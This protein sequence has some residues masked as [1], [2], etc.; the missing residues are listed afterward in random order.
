[1]TVWAMQTLAVCGMLTLQYFKCMT[2]V[3]PVGLI[4]KG[5]TQRQMIQWEQPR[6]ISHC[7]RQYGTPYRTDYSG[8]YACTTEESGN[9]G[10][11]VFWKYLE[12]CHLII[13][14]IKRSETDFISKYPVQRW[15]MFSLAQH[16][17]WRQG[18]TAGHAQS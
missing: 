13:N 18:E 2:V 16:K 3:G 5:C 15:D 14:Q 17:E 4:V 9:F 10:N 1:M 8:V 6:G 7:K 11:I 12:V